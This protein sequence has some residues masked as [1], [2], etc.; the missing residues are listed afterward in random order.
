MKG[1]YWEEWEIGSEVET[2]ARTVTEADIVI[3]AGL[4]GDYNPL[5]TDEE[6][7]KTTPFGGRIAHGPLVYG[8]AA[9]LLFQLHL[10][11]DTMIALLGF[12][13]LRFTKPV[14][15]GDTIRA[16]VKVLE[17]KETSKPDRGVIKR[18]LHVL[19]QRGEVVQESIQNILLKRK[20]A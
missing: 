9:G 13:D 2:S 20:P 5:H 3:Y 11:D 12:E 17:K 15:P 19:N 8:I 7:C 18:Q 1:L 16:R 14:K 6:Y 4:S 10:Y